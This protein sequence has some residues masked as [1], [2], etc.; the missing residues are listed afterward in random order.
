MDEKI[1]TAEKKVLVEIVKLTQKREM[2]GSKGDWK[3]FLRIYDK[4]F[5][6]SLS[7]PAKRAPDALAAFLKTFSQEDDL[8]FFAK[9][10]QCHSNRGIVEQFKTKSP[11]SETP[12]QRLVHTTLEH[13]LYPLD[14]SFGS[15][16]EDWVV[17][18]LKKK[19]KLTSSTAML[20]V[21]CEMVLCSDG[22]EALVKVCVVDHNLEVKLN[23]LVNP[24]KT[25]A[26]YRTEITGVTAAD[27]DGVT[28]SLA[29]VQKSMKKLLSGRTILVGHS[30]HNDLRAL[31]MNHVR[32]I[33]TSYIFQ[34]SDGP[35]RRRPSL[36]N[37]CK[38]VLGF[39]VRKKGASH[40]CL[41]DA[42]AAMKLVLAK[43][44]HGVDNV[45]PLVQEPVAETE[46]TKLLIHMIPTGVHSEELHEV[47]PGNFT[48]ELKPPKKD[49]Y[50][51]FAIF[52]TS[53]E[54]HEAYENVKGI[55]EKDTFGRPQKLV[56]FQLRTGMTA[57]L[58]VRKM[59]QEEPNDQMSSK[60]RALVVEETYTDYKKAKKDPKLEED[61]TTDSNHR[62]NHLKE[63][64]TLSEQL[65]QKDSEIESLT[66]Q[67]K[68]KDFEISVLN[69]MISSFKEGK[70]KKR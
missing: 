37:L 14:Y 47:L 55:Q 6:S 50:S 40:N 27:L 10:M 61:A 5:G 70:R 33:D 54:A 22:T 12:E 41:D 67:L 49:K 23:E 69:K 9:I 18:N 44:E 34:F 36:N 68:Q 51:A 26:D 11:D 56:A 52:K 7:D 35:T 1:D 65:K 60:K 4:K 45:I 20:A 8:K 29:D 28:C 21:D 59:A 63:I 32:V 42:C 58:Y 3:E 43:I 62:G 64:D 57:N 48:I 24:L 30:L 2:K 15:N 16:N 38:S 19:S 13:P 66:Q 53:K 39:E 25:V 17:V 46:M 31:K